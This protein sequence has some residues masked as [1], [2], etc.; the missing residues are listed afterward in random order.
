MK[1]RL[2]NHAKWLARNVF[3]HIKGGWK[4]YVRRLKQD[5]R[6]RIPGTNYTAP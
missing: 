4:K 6:F 5:P 2:R 1:Y 3:A